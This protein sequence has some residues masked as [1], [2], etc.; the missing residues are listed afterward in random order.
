MVRSHKHA[1]QQVYVQ[2]FTL[3]EGRKRKKLKHK[4]KKETRKLYK[5]PVSKGDSSVQSTE[6]THPELEPIAGTSKSVALLASAVHYAKCKQVVS[7]V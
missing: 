6:S 4:N 2:I 1:T 7:Q 3:S 5:F